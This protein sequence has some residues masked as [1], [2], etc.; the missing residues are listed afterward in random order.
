MKI[1][2]KTF[3]KWATKCKAEVISDIE[4][5]LGMSPRDYYNPDNYYGESY[6]AD[7]GVE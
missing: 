1:D 3:D 5:D 6:Y 4:K 2:V 7:L